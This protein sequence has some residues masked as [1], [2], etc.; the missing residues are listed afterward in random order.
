MKS[1]LAAGA[2]LTL[3]ACGA[4]PEPMRA[5]EAA[6]SLAQFAA[7]ET[8]SYLGTREGREAL[9]SAVRAHGREM[10]VN[11]LVWPRF[12]PDPGRPA[13]AMDLAVLIAFSA[14]FVER[15]DLMRAAQRSAEQVARDHLSE[16]AHLRDASR[17]ACAEAAEAQRTAVIYMAAVEQQQ[18][19]GVFA[20]RNG[21]AAY[22]LA[23]VHYEAVRRAERQMR[24]AL[25]DVQARLE[26]A[27][28]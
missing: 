26:R 5:S 18:A 6:A 8:P 27:D 23:R 13:G 20:E 11:G 7:V 12:D 3:A 16:I 19:L 14:G 17:R 24:L 25:H 2:A 21:G 22:D 28:R 10:R 1:I 15:D 9:R 4:A